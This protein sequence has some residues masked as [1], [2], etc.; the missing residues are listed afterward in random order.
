[1]LSGSCFMSLLGSG[2]C[3]MD[4]QA[5]CS[6]AFCFIEFT[7]RTKTGSQPVKSELAIRDFLENIDTRSFESVYNKITDFNVFKVESP[8]NVSLRS[9]PKFCNT[10]LLGDQWKKY[11]A[12]HNHG[13]YLI[14][15]WYPLLIFIIFLSQVP[16]F[17]TSWWNTS[18]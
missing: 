8:M 6:N 4:F 7:K 16:Q 13:R 1:M 10:F 18:K 5:F 17:G 3:T 12:K 11:N 9:T 15:I 2:L 14:G